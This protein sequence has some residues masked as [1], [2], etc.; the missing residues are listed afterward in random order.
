MFRHDVSC[1]EAEQVIL[2]GFVEIEYQVVDG[3]E[4]ELVVGHTN[5]GRFLT[6]LWTERSGA[7]RRS[8]LGTQPAKKKS[9]TGSL[10]E[11]RTMSRKRVIPK[12]ATEAEEVAWWEKNRGM[13]GKDLGEAVAKG[14][15][16]FVT[17]QQ[18]AARL[19][20]RPVTIRLAEADIKLAQ[21]QA[22]RKGLPYQTYIRSLLHET[23]VERER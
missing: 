10:K 14:E 2:N 19:A 3:E 11:L 22:E 9:S 1:S 4:R 12:F 21:K 7:V 13:I 8:R 17:P 15:A 5:A 6:L 18:L 23:L 20:A 16:K